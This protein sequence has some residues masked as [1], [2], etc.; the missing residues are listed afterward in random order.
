MGEVLVK[1][2]F[3][4]QLP[5]ETYFQKLKKHKCGNIHCRVLLSAV[6]YFISSPSKPSGACILGLPCSHFM[7]DIEAQRG[8][9]ACPNRIKRDGAE[10]PAVWLLKQTVLSRGGPGMTHVYP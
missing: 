9:V 1:S 10:T 7:G 6:C 5:E 3:L 4:Q 8:R 2:A